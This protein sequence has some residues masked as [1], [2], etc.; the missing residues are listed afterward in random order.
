MARKTKS[1]LGITEMYVSLADLIR[2]PN[3]L[4]KLGL[5]S[6]IHS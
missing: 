4:S 2:H 3:K 6:T 1:H 5:K